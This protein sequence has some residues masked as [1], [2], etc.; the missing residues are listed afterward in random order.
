MTEM[1]TL[2][3]ML[4]IGQLASQT[5]ETVKTLRY[6]TNHGLLESVRGENGYRYYPPGMA[7]RVAFIRNAQ[8]LGFSLTDIGSILT[9]RTE[10]VSPCEHVRADLSEHLKNVQT[11]IADLQVLYAELS[12]RLAWAEAHP[13]PDCETQGCIY[14]RKTL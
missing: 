9:L 6:W 2:F 7:G 14:L 1:F 12:K 4:S 10:G 5:S 8:A 11:R 3:V 13:D